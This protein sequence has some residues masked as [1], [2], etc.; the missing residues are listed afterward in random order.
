MVTD[1]YSGVSITIRS[2][3][4]LPM[5]YDHRLIDGAYS[6]QLMQLVKKHLKTWGRRLLG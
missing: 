3:M 1:E 4:Y 6:A 2:M 5:S